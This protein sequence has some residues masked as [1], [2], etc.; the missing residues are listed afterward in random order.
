MTTTT[1]PSY[2]AIVTC[3]NSETTISEAI[4]SLMKQTVKPKAVIVVDDGS[5][6]KTLQ[7][8][9]SFMH[10][11][12]AE[13]TLG[14]I[15]QVDNGYDITR[16]VKNW[17]QALSFAEETGLFAATDYHLISADDVFY[18][19]EYAEKVLSKLGGAFVIGSGVSSDYDNVSVESSAMP[20]GAG[21]FVSNKFL[22]EHC[23]NAR[24]PERIG[25][26]AYILYLAEMKGYLSRVYS[27]AKF[28]HARKLGSGHKFYEFGAGMKALGY[29]PL[30][31][32]GRFLSN[33]LKGK[34]IGRIGAFYMLYYYLTFKLQPAGYNSLF[35][36]EVRNY[37]RQKQLRRIKSILL[38]P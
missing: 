29:H 18:E 13:T 26:E 1:I 8:L 20:R 10:K 6:D 19:Q 9:F 16:V 27:E 33:L 36:P 24:Y 34:P 15:S 11:K 25:Y 3:R 14:I 2:F 4:N 7:I 37:I 22:K 38:K 30:F 31:V 5:T 28:T 35:E 32:F 12:P 17:N 23:P 21:R